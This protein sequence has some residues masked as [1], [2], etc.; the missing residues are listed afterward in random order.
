M[1]AFF[2]AR[3]EQHYDLRQLDPVS[4]DAGKLSAGDRERL[5]AVHA[6]LCTQLAKPPTLHECAALAGM[7]INKLKFGFQ[8]LFGTSIYAFSKNRRLHEARL[9]LESGALPVK[10]VARQ[11]GYSAAG[12]STVFRQRF[13]VSPS[14]VIQT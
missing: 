7:N 4:A 3:I 5:Y 13:G 1:L 14:A 12:F 8:Q 2:L 6:T 9:L 11:F 10:A